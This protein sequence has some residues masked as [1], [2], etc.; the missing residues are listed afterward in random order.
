MNLRFPWCTF[1][2]FTISCIAFQWQYDQIVKCTKGLDDITRLRSYRWYRPQCAVHKDARAWWLYAISC[3]YP[4][5][6]PAIC[7]PKP[8]WESCLL[9]AKQNVQYVNI[10][11]KILVTPALA[12]TSEEKQLKDTVEWDRDFD[13]LKVLREVRKI[14]IL[15]L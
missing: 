14:M 7:R 6:Q 8:T 3:L 15:F 12:L 9:K 10:Y 11:S 13:E 2:Y 4:G 5:G 1:L